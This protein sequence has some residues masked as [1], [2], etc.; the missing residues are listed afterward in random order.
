MSS[1]SVIVQALSACSSPANAAVDDQAGWLRQAITVRNEALR[2][3]QDRFTRDLQSAAAL[4]SGRGPDAFAAEL[5]YADKLTADYLAESEKLFALMDRLAQD[6]LL[7][8]S[9]KGEDTSPTPV[10]ARCPE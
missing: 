3:L 7:D 10:N 9:W 2:L 5:K 4:V 6:G 8:V 1:R